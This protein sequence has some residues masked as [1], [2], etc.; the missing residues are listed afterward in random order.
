MNYRYGFENKRKNNKKRIIF[1]II[2]IILVIMF[3]SLFFR[4]STNKVVSNIT[5]VISY[6]Q[7]IFAIF[8]IPLFN[9]S[10]TNFFIPLLL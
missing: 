9:N 7:I 2:F 8:L 5:N 4:H 3:A 1:V 10:I 6:P